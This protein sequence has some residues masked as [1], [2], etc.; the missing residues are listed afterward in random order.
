M[1]QLELRGKSIGKVD[2]IIFDK[3]GTL[4]NS[5]KHLFRLA[6]LRILEA[7]AI[8]LRGQILSPLMP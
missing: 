7:I 4:T 8:E 5:E 2:C 6:N 1:P 3:D